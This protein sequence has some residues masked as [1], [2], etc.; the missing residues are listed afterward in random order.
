[1]TATDRT[2]T[3]PSGS[4]VWK[5]F[6]CDWCGAERLD[7]E[8]YGTGWPDNPQEWCLWPDHTPQGRGDA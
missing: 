8:V 5:I 4:R 6:I 1:M 2:K 3:S 7:F